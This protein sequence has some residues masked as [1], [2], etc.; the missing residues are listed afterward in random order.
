MI[1]ESVISVLEEKCNKCFKCISVCPVKSCNSA[2]GDSVSVIHESCLGCGACV[3]EC[4]SGARIV[5]DDITL[6][7]EK[8]KKESFIAIVAPAV[9]SV[10]PQTYK[11]LNGYLKKIGI[12]AVFDVSFGA[13]LAT[14]SY[15][16]YIK[17]HNPD[18]VITQPC[19]SLVNYI[20]K[21]QPELLPHLA[22]VD[23]PMLHTIK[24][25]REFFREYNDCNVVVLSPCAA[26]RLEFNDTYPDALNVTFKSLID[27]FSNMNVRL[28]QFEEVEYSGSQA[29]RAVLFSSPG[30]LKRTVERALPNISAQIRKVEGRE[31]VY[32]Y[33][34]GLKKSINNGTSPLIVDCLN[35][36]LGCNGGP[37]TGNS[38]KSID[39]LE[40]S[41]EKRSDSHIKSNKKINREINSYWKE[42]LF[43]RTYKNRSTSVTINTPTSDQLKEIFSSMH[44]NGIDDI[45]NCTSCGYNSCERMAE[46]IFNGINEPGNCHHYQ[47]SVL[48]EMDNKNKEIAELL[49]DEVKKSNNLTSRARERMSAMEE[50]TSQQVTAIEE[51][52]AAVEEMLASIRSISNISNTRKDLLEKMN[53]SFNSVGDELSRMVSSVSS[54]EESVGVV[55]E[56]NKLIEDVAERTNLLSMNAAIEAARAGH[57]GKG[58][59]VVAGEIKKLADA[60]LSNAGQIQESLNGITSYVKESVAISK[61]SKDKSKDMAHLVSQVKDS[62]NEI[63]GGMDEI[64]IGSDEIS[65][66]LNVMS[67][68]SRDIE[69]LYSEVKEVMNDMMGMIYDMENLLGQL[70][71]KSEEHSLVEQQ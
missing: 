71:Q 60:S 34:S 67:S 19:P 33:L 46:A 50:F 54:I 25:I 45:Y 48:S 43:N 20:E 66:S 28:S 5:N 1:R 14:K 55:D 63:A 27:H 12:K 22:P 11:K 15:I 35:C 29:E 17:K 23:S 37:G 16:E 2:V 44:K 18:T 41:I 52:S 24:Y 51:S 38:N 53:N 69:E 8:I 70:A 57:T 40:H 3:S 9:V 7:F 10:F 6:F 30:G 49:E 56:M 61:E 47:L 58:F 59:A 64:A 32:K 42:N 31:T 62:F 26:K 68:S 39:E 21:Y 65:Q 4:D 36:E 13:E